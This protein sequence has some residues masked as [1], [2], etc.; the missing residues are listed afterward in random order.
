MIETDDCRGTTASISQKRYREQLLGMNS[1]RR[2]GGGVAKK[3]KLA[4]VADPTVGRTMSKSASSGVDL[5]QES[6]RNRE[7]HEGT[8]VRSFVKIYCHKN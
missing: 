4:G 3:H 6:L 2:K 5:D 8:R 7:P 1:D